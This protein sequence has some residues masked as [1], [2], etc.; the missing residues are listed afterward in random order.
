M[1]ILW[2]IDSGKQ[3][4]RRARQDT[5]DL[6]SLAQLGVFPEHLSFRLGEL[7]MIFVWIDVEN[8]SGHARSWWAW[9]TV[10][11]KL[12]ILGSRVSR[13]TAYNLIGK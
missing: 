11:A 1:I 3:G 8:L 2:N 6:E 10:V 5:Y 12:V 9:V 13:S 4:R 7:R